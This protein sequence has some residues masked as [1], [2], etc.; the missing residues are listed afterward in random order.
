MDTNSELQLYDHVEFLAPTNE[1]HNNF[2]RLRSTKNHDQC[3]NKAINPN[4]K[5]IF[6]SQKN[7]KKNEAKVSN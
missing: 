1:E 3:K 5:T 6:K 2:D 4:F 7:W